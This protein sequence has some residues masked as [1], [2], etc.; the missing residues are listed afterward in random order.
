LQKNEQ[1]FDFAKKIKDRM[2]KNAEEDEN[3]MRKISLE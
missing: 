1:K 2:Q 3:F